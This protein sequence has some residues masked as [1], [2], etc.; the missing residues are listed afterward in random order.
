MKRLLPL[1]FLWTLAQADGYAQLNSAFLDQLSVENGLS[2]SEVSCVLKDRRGYVWLGTQNGLNRFDGYRF[3]HY[4]HDPFNARTLSNDHILSLWESTDGRLWVGTVHGLNA[5]D[6]TTDRFTRYEIPLDP[7]RKLKSLVVHT[8]TDDSDGTLWL[9]TSRGARR[10]FIGGTAGVPTLVPADSGRFRL[11]G[12]VIWTLHRDRKNRIWAGTQQGLFRL[13]ADGRTPLGPLVRLMGQSVSSVTD[14]ADGRL[15]LAADSGLFRFDVAHNVLASAEAAGLPREG[16]SALLADRHRVLWVGTGDQGI[17][18]YQIQPDGTLRPL[19]CIRENVFN[20]QGLKSS[21]VTCLHE[22][23]APG[24]DVV[25]IGTKDAG[26]HRFSRS[27]NSFR[28]WESITATG[29]SAAANL[30]FSLCTDRR[31]QLWAGTYQGLFRIDR[32]TGR[33]RQYRHDPARRGSLGS[34]R[35]QALLEDRRGRLWVGTDAGLF[36][37]D[38]AT[39]SFEPV[40]LGEGDEPYVLRL[41]EDRTGN[42]WVGAGYGLYKIEPDGRQRVFPY[43]PKDPATLQAYIVSSIQE[44][45]DNHLWV[46]TAIGLNKIDRATGKI[47]RFVNDPKNP[48]SLIGNEVY[49]LVLDAKKRLWVCSNKGLSRVGNAGGKET[50]VHVGP[51]DGLP[52]DVVYGALPDAR[53]RLWVST[54]FGLSCFDPDRHTFRNYDAADGLSSNEFNMGAFHRSRNGEFFFGGI[55][56]LVSFDPLRMTEN[57]HVPNVVLSSFEKFEKTINV[58]SLLDRRG[59]LVLGPGDNFFSFVFTA[60]DFT[61]PTKNQY[62]Y[63]LEGFDEDW[64][65]SGTRRYASFTNLPPGDYTLKVKASNSDGVWNEE[66]VLRVPLTITPPFWR[67]WWFL[68]VV[69]LTLGLAARVFYN[70]RVRTRVAHLLELEKVKLAENERVRRLAAQDLHDEFGNTITRISMLTELIKSRLNGHGQDVV[71]LLTKI[72]DNSN[73]MYQ[74]TKDFIWAINPEHDNFYEIAIRLKDFGDDVFDKT[75]IRFEVD[76]LTEDLKRAVLP[77][78]ASRH[79]VFL[80]KEAMSNTLKHAHPTRTLLRFSFDGERIRVDWEDD[81]AGFETTGTSRGNGLQNMES[82][83]RKI[84]GTVR[85]HSRTGGGTQVTFGMEIA[86]TDVPQSG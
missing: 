19:D 61:N 25:W 47:S 79:L 57:R 36:R 84:G 66:T 68:A 62:A 72:S 40:P 63:Q 53:G 80:F 28:H 24:E 9:G 18:R 50:F 8:I 83:A 78:G 51:R 26:V 59:R 32:A 3:V 27:K 11:D 67:T 23:P 2:Q 12:Q 85:V 69:V 7:K 54:N 77:M 46:G 35:V 15:W 64:I 39:D 52:N 71:P 41:Y 58:D 76:G 45:A 13:D 16:I 30:I 86:R 33:F 4:K 70:Y 44:D 5:Y 31:G 73:R 38:P 65:H 34:D 56:T 6:P 43:N 82:R 81:G 29:K 75:G 37:F 1:F 14:D 60:L 55:G 48:A 17:C 22:G 42:L 20:K 74:G 10:F 49:D 21:F